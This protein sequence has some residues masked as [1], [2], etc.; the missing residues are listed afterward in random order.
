MPALLSGAAPFTVHS[1]RITITGVTTHLSRKVIEELTAVVGERDVLV[2]DDEL[3]VYECDGMVT[4]RHLP[5]AVVVP[6]SAEEVAG[7]VRVLGREGVPFLARGAGTGLSGGAVA[8]AGG[9]VIEMA[10]MNRVL[11]VDAENRIA[12]VESGLVNLKLTNEVAPISLVYAPDPSSQMACTIGGN[13]AENSGGPHCLKYGVTMNHVL[14]VEA[15]LPDGELVR[16]GG[17][18]ADAVGYDLLGAF[19]GSEGTFG[20]VTKVWLRLLKAPDTIRTMLA[21]FTSIGDASRAVSSIIAAGI[22]PAALEMMDQ[23]TVQ[24][25]EASV[26][27][28]G[29]PQDAAAIL[30]IELD[31]FAVAVEEHATRVIDLVKSCGAR[32]LRLAKDAADRVRIWMGRKGAFGAMGRISPD[33]MVQDAV[34]PRT[35]LPD[36]LPKIV[37]IGEKYNLRVANVFHA[38][39]GNLH[40]NISYDLRDADETQRVKKACSEIMKLCVDAGGSISGEHGIGM[41][42]MNYMSWIFS[43]TDLAAMNDLRRCFNP[44]GLLNPGKVLPNRTCGYEKGFAKLLDTV[45]A[46]TASV[47][48]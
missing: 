48:R 19:V 21:G 34:I 42:K 6:D 18:G 8:C 16:M 22:L 1:F 45:P 7:I 33:L 25:V 35:M 41:D 10:R 5:D 23:R 38:G 47:P 4:Y 12:V 39:D 46:E 9:V 32:N 31:G 20:I 27:A 24:A 36:L 43:E 44:S 17:C 13:V 15:V 37:E 40:P 3:M 30:I 28:A 29:F 2:E 26:F 11:D 14:G